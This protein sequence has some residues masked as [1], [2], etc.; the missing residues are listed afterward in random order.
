[1]FPGHFCFLKV[2][3]TLNN[4]LSTVLFFYFS[5]KC[6]IMHRSCYLWLLLC[7]AQY[8]RSNLIQDYEVLNNKFLHPQDE[9]SEPL[10]IELGKDRSSGCLCRASINNRL[11]VCFGNYECMKFPKVTYYFL[12]KRAFR[13]MVGR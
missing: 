4:Y 1:M 3:N 13:F 8:A 2:L 11:V 5:I 12:F 7:Y 10:P 9:Q 6:C